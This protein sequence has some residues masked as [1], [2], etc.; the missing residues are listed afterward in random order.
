MTEQQAVATV[1]AYRKLLEIPKGM[2]VT[3]AEKA[4]VMARSGPEAPLGDDRI[5]WIVELTWPMG[6]MRVSVDDRSGEVIG[7]ERSA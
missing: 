5:G 1:E 2:R 4:I 6:F 3:R 7:V